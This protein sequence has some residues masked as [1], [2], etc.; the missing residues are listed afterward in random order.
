MRPA[1]RVIAKDSGLALL[2]A[3][4]MSAI[5][6]LLSLSVLHNVSTNIE[7]SRIDAERVR[8]H[9]LHLAGVRYAALH[10][11][12]PRHQVAPTA[13]PSEDLS[14]ELAAGRIQLKIENEAGRIDLLRASSTVLTSILNHFGVPVSNL[15]A[16][17]REIQSLA[18]QS[19]PPSYRSLRRILRPYP[20]LYHRLINHVTL[21]NGKAGVHPMIASESLLALLPGMSLADQQQVLSNRENIEGSLVSSPIENPLFSYTL[22]AFYRITTTTFLGDSTRTNVV[23]IKMTKQPG[24][25]YQRVASL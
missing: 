25:L 15:D 16:L 12:S 5:L 4:W 20:N 8:Y 2:S 22:S 24:V 11:A 13:T 1:C 10:L 14:F 6:A 18:S 23:I 3:V 17:V 7:A 19:H 9:L 21:H